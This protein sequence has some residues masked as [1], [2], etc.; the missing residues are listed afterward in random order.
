MPRVSLALTLGPES[1]GRLFWAGS[2]MTRSWAG[3][4]RALRPTGARAEPPSAG[5]SRSPRPF[6]GPEDLGNGRSRAPVCLTPGERPAGTMSPV[7]AAVIVTRVRLP[8]APWVP[9]L[10]RFVPEAATCSLQVRGV[11]GRTGRWSPREV[12]AELGLAGGSGRRRGGP[13]L[14]P[15]L[16]GPGRALPL[17]PR[18]PFCALRGAWR[19][20]RPGEGLCHLGLSRRNRPGC[21][22][23]A[24]AGYRARRPTRRHPSPPLWLRGAAPAS[25]AELWPGSPAGEAGWRR[26]ARPRRVS[27]ALS[28][29]S[30][31][32]STHGRG[33]AGRGGR[34]PCR[35]PRPPPRGAPLELVLKTAEA[36]IRRR[37]CF[38]SSDL[39]SALG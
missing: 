21:Q 9:G 36:G 3:R 14:V 28:D 29:Q 1:C 4:G 37:S 15:A 13:G 23:L 39:F 16:P 19:R 10:V 35:P 7:A 26:R 38:V 2:C 17:A 27:R 5:R 25:W 31:C 34:G 6:P 8:P 12:A 22:P 20:R 24:L 11:E 32:A 33:A 30:L 18:Q